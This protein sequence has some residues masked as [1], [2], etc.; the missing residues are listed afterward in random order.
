MNLRNLSDQEL[1]MIEE[2]GATGFVPGEI[3]EVLEISK[4]DFIR[5]FQDPAGE[6]YRRYRKG[7]LKAQ[8]ELRQRIMKD[9]KHGSSPAQ[10]LMKKIFD[11]A[12]HL[13]KQL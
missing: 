3:A 7:Y 10:T 6:I 8:L 5:T 2:M 4:D 12:D 13:L 1:Q 9:A 11:D